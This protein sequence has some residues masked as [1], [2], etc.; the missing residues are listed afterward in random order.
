[1][2]LPRILVLAVIDALEK[3]LHEE[4]QADRVLEKILKS[5]KK[6]GSRDRAF[7]AE[8]T[9][10]LIRYFRLYQ[11]CSQKPHTHW[12]L[13]A[14]YFVLKQISLPPWEEYQQ[15]D[16]ASVLQKFQE[17]LPHRALRESIPNWLDEQGER[18]LGALLWEKELHALN[19]PAEVVLRVN[20]L[21]IT[22]EEL[23]KNLAQAY[24]ETRLLEGEAYP[25]ALVL[26][27]RQ[28]LF[29]TTFFQEGYFELQDASSQQ[30][31][32]FLQV[33]SGMRVIDACAGAGGKSL[34]LAA[35]MKNKGTLLCLDTE[36][37]KLEELRKRA[38]RNGVQLIE[39]RPLTSSK[40]IKRLHH[41]ADRVLL[42]VPC[43]GLGVLRR[44]PDAKWKLNPAYLERLR[45]TQKEILARYSLMVKPGGKLLYATCSIFPSENQKQIQDFLEKNSN[46]YLEEEKSLFSSQTGFDGFYMA[47]LARQN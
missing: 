11:Y 45:E 5:N 27:K 1:L 14:A 15:Q 19:Q 43:S 22:K 8:T 33:E 28:N 37:W 35:L 21:K 24:I 20:R 41:S 38:R 32:P 9:Y 46:F 16:P 23:Q 4:Q 2:K 12:D 36:S 17:A 40:I 42:D 47:R 44:N 30:V 13:T 26:Q 39:T 10:T 3:I 34:H 6:W 7:I 25:D 29:K 31:A 18:E